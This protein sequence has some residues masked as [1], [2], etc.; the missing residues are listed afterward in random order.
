MN[1][2]IGIFFWLSAIYF[3]IKTSI[4]SSVPVSDAFFLAIVIIF[5]YFVNVNMVQTNCG[6][7]TTSSTA[8]KATLFPWI[9]IFG[10]MLLALYMFPEWKKPFSNTF[11]YL[12]ARIAGGNK[13]LIDLLNPGQ[14]SSLHYVY[15]DPSLLINQFTP[16]NFD[17]MLAS[18]SK[19]TVVTPEKR[20]AF[21]Q[22]VKLK[23]AVSE[24]IWYLLTAS[25]VISTSSSMIMNGEC[26]KSADDYVL[27]HN[28]AMADS[29]Q[30]PTSMQP[31]MYS[32]TE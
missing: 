2:S 3:Y 13:A 19:I 4:L 27:A 30:L 28:I 9:G 23:D 5:M 18:F 29:N 17:A 10:P 16:T 14:E 8:F 25:I 1:V 15:N 12:I 6:G 11:G 31:T 22:I 21:L 24:W 26:T 32:I 20:N 7:L